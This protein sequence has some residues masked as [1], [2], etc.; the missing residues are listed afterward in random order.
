VNFTHRAEIEARYSR[1]G[2]RL[3]FYG[4]SHNS[5]QLR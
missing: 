3:Q 1:L 5:G 4:S 2:I